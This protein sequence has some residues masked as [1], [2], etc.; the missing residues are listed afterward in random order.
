MTLRKVDNIRNYVISSRPVPSGNVVKEEI[1]PA[2]VPLVEKQEVYWAL[3][4]TVLL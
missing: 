4:K 2:H 3:Y 1:P